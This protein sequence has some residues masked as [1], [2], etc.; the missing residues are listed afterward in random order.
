VAQ[1]TIDRG[2]VVPA[3]RVAPHSGQHVHCRG[4][5][6]WP[7]PRSALGPDPMSHDS[8]APALNNDP[9]KRAM[10]RASRLRHSAVAKH[11]S[12]VREACKP[13]RE[14]PPALESMYASLDR[15][16]GRWL[17]GGCERSDPPCGW[18][19]CNR[20]NAAGF[21]PWRPEAVEGV[22]A[23][24]GESTVPITRRAIAPP[25]SGGA[26]RLVA[27]RSRGAPAR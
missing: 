20:A 27:L 22:R 23:G 11:S 6:R 9:V 25:T 26:R 4:P 16:D 24:D 7:S 14:R 19:S 2:G 5:L 18:P 17:G 21:T 15:H 8:T 10:H 13:R 12:N 1:M 3:L